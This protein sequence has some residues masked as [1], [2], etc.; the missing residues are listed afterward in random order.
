MGNLNTSPLPARKELGCW[1]M[2][3]SVLAAV[4]IGRVASITMPSVFVVA[5]LDS[6]VAWY[7]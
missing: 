7:Q 2:Q 6:S 5:R 1:R 4:D 3:P